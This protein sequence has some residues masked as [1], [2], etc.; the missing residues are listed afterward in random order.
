MGRFSL[1]YENTNSVL[2]LELKESETDPVI[3]MPFILAV[4]A[5]NLLSKLKTIDQTRDTEFMLVA[6]PDIEEVCLMAEAMMDVCPSNDIFEGKSK[7]DAVSMVR[8][9]A[10]HIGAI[11][12]YLFHDYIAFKGRLDEMKS[13]ASSSLSFDFAKLS[14]YNIP[15]VAQYLVA[16]YFRPHVT[17]PIS[18]LNYE[19]AAAEYFNSLSGD[20]RAGMM[21]A[22]SFSSFE[23]RYL[24]D[25]ALKTHIKAL[26]DLKILKC[27]RGLVLNIRLQEQ[28]L[29]LEEY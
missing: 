16:P 14:V 13:S 4:S 18:A 12:R 11:P 3:N 24:C 29:N 6:P 1:D 26:K 8:E 17:N 27:L 7:E 21:H 9:R 19:E 10:L 23:F 15:K 25:Y 20:D 5:G 28:S 2:I 22:R